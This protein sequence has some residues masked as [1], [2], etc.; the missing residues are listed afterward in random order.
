MDKI[1]HELCESFF[2]Y[3]HIHK[4]QFDLHK[5][6]QQIQKLGKRPSDQWIFY[7]NYLG[8]ALACR[9]IR[10]ELKMRTEIQL[11]LAFQ[12]AP[13][14]IWI[15]IYK[16]INVVWFVNFLRNCTVD[17]FFIIYISTIDYLVDISQIN[18]KYKIHKNIIFMQYILKLFSGFVQILGCIPGK[19]Y[20]FSKY[21]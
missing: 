15:Y 6:Q 14:T 19:H 8:T 5:Q 10:D 1:D 4:N 2:N 16:Y 18:I 13:F 20:S 3:C 17:Q 12:F 21:T 9:I 11:W 7:F